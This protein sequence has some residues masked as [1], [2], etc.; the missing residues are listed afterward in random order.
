[1][2]ILLVAY[3]LAPVSD[4]PVGGSEQVLA[5]LDRALTQA[6]HQVTVIA[7][8]GSITRGRLHAIPVTAGPIDDAIRHRAHWA[9]REA[10]AAE[11]RHHDLVHYHGLDFE[12]YLP[13][14]GLPT[15]ATLHLPLDWYSWTS[16]DPTRPD[17]WLN[18]VS[19]S[20]L[21]RAPWAPSHLL[22]P[23]RNGVDVAR[24]APGRARDYLLFLGR[25]CPEKGVETALDAATQAGARLLLAGELYPYPEHQAWFAERVRPRLGARARWL[26][27]VTGARKARLLAGARAVLVPSTVAE[28]GSLV[29]ME[30][31]ASGT[32]V[33]GSA[34]GEIPNLLDEGVT[35]FT[36]QPGDATAFAAAIA[37]IGELSR[38]AARAAALRR[39]SVERTTDAYI[40]LYRRLIATSARSLAPV[41][42]TR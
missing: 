37:R 13:P 27:P 24:Y 7:Q 12:A 38:S 3:S 31:L 32:P 1:M 10:I 14:E 8:D 41:A 22:A 29:T 35:G 39:F 9:M 36:C 21:A 34:I 23:V 28:T 40:A 15:L 11:A 33:I 16:L 6:G 17:T 18:P 20:Q 26:G 25:M 4:D 2:R 19:E 5:Q 42:L 30:A